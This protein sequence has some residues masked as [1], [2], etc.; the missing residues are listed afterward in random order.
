[1]LNAKGELTMKID[2]AKIEG[3]NEMTA[4][5]KLAALESFEYEDNSAELERLKNA[6]SK[7]NSE[8]A[9]WK[10]KHNALLTE[11]EQ[12]KA[13][14]EENNK[15]I[16]EELETLRKDKT[17]SDYTA[18]YI[19]I[20]YDK[21][22]ASETAKAMA[23]GDMAK[24]FENGEKHRQALEKK[25]KED[26]INGTHK[27]DGAG[28]DDKKV[29]SAIEKAKALAKAKNGGEKSYNDIMSKYKK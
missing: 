6:N 9:E 20:G 19:A 29:D 23:D 2:T 8:A 12:K 14:A 28:G 22:L 24:V 5:Q 1:M 7:A 26:L 17:I 4:E 13:E 18:K 16:L 3:Y 11:E 25:I 27:P 15:K 21:D 10:R